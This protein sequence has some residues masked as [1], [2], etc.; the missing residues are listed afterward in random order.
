MVMVKPKKTKNKTSNLI[1]N[2]IKEK[3]LKN[4]SK[5]KKNKNDCEMSIKRKVFQKKR[6]KAMKA[7]IWRK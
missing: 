3:T 7:H 6:A 2:N 4:S 5:A 1:K